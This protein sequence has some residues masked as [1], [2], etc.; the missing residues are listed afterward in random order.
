MGQEELPLRHL[1]IRA[2]ATNGLLKRPS[3]SPPRR[4]IRLSA[5]FREGISNTAGGLRTCES[6]S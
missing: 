1:V 5:S 6:W 3:L 4:T 2:K